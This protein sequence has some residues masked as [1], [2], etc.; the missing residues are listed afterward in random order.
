MKL[1]TMR[2]QSPPR[3]LLRRPVRVAGSIQSIA[4]LS[5]LL[6]VACGA[7]GDATS[8]SVATTTSVLSSGSCNN[9]ES[10]QLT[11]DSG[12][13]EI[14]IPADSRA[15]ADLFY[16]TSVGTVEMLGRVYYD[17]LTSRG[18][19][20]VP[21]MSE[22]DPGQADGM[23]YGLYRRCLDTLQEALILIAEDEGASDDLK[24][25]VQK[26]LFADSESESCP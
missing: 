15:I 16:L 24:L 7:N 14:P 19:T 9:A 1:G 23:S 6:L 18:W 26:G 11:R 22:L 25:S 21:S 10:C 3:R 17:V 20:F 12:I 5:A 2:R 13:Y 4:L 8:T